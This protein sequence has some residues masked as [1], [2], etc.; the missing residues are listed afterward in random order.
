MV[1]ATKWSS[2]LSFCRDSI[3]PGHGSS[4][5]SLQCFVA[6]WTLSWPS[7][8]SMENTM[9]QSYLCMYVAPQRRPLAHGSGHSRT[10]ILCIRD[11]HF[12]QRPSL[13]ESTMRVSE[14]RVKH[15]SHPKETRSRKGYIYCVWNTI[16]SSFSTSLQL[17]ANMKYHCCK[18]EELADFVKTRRLTVTS[19]A[20]SGPTRQDYLNALRLVDKHI[21]FRFLDLPAEMRVMVYEGLLTL[22]ESGTCYPKILRAC[23]HIHREAERIL[24]NSNTVNITVTLDHARALNVTCGNY[25]KPCKLDLSNL[26]WPQFLH[27]VR[28]LTVD[29]PVRLWY[30]AASYRNGCRVEDLNKVLYSL[31]P[32]L[33][34]SNKLEWIHLDKSGAVAQQNITKREAF[35]YSLGLLRNV[36]KVTVGGVDD[37]VVNTIKKTAQNARLG[38]KGLSGWTLT[39]KQAM[40]YRA[41]S[42]AI[43]NHAL[44]PRVARRS[45]SGV[46]LHASTL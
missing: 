46:R 3:L 7:A 42:K 22:S 4:L 10:R 15:Q 6:W 9:H 34:C 30:P 28:K 11:Q 23:K 35:L 41:L 40:A 14:R 27:R 33:E 45:Y 2:R 44:G 29:T 24:Y 5:I 38:R 16:N 19:S 21:T 18:K 8:L 1:L 20:I 43:G 13:L 12:A 31:C 26:E 25:S 39:L 17:L 32:F 37:K 36:P